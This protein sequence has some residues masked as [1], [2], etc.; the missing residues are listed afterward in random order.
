M[1]TGPQEGPRTRLA[2]A[3]AEWTVTFIVADA[4][5][6]P[7]TRGVRT[8][9]DPPF[10]P[11]R[12]TVVFTFSTSRAPS[13][14]LWRPVRLRVAGVPQVSGLPD[15]VEMN[16]QADPVSPDAWKALVPDWLVRRIEWVAAAGPGMSW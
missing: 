4:P 6:M 12:V 16:W 8:P 7:L 1:T 3:F 13:E 5:P 10:R 11:D 2:G 14:P 15:R 9:Q